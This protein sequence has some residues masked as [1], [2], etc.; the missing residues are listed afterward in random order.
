MQPLCPGY[1]DL[2]M[3]W[4]V[5]TVPALRR[6]L[7]AL[8]NLACHVLRACCLPQRLA[9]CLLSS[10]SSSA[11]SAPPFSLC[12]YSDT[13][14]VERAL[15]NTAQRCTTS[16]PTRLAVSVH[17]PCI[18]RTALRRRRN[19]TAAWSSHPPSRRLARR[20][21]PPRARRSARG[22]MKQPLQGLIQRLQ[23]GCPSNSPHQA[24]ETDR[25]PGKALLSNRVHH[26]RE[27]LPRQLVAHLQLQLRYTFS[28]NEATHCFPLSN[29]RS[30]ALHLQCFCLLQLSQARQTH[31][32]AL[33][34]SFC[35]FKTTKVTAVSA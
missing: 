16:G 2:C 5:H 32:N 4:I 21:P 24:L 13:L 9:H 25:L 31:L 12:P 11:R 33:S 1:D 23:T 22:W 29:Q 27:Q 7:T 35:L 19:S 14:S 15:R 26:Q 17:M 8:E 18:C 6:I 30:S 10:V 3:D 34:M 20:A 28:L